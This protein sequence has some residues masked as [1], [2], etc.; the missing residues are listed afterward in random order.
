MQLLAAAAMLAAPT[1]VGL[2]G[3][4]AAAAVW[5]RPLWVGAALLVL[6]VPFGMVLP[7]AVALD[8]EGIGRRFSRRGGIYYALQAGGGVAGAITLGLVLP[9]HIGFA[10]TL[11]ALAGG[12]GLLAIGLLALRLTARRSEAASGAPADGGRPPGRRTAMWLAL[13]L[14]MLGL[15]GELMW[16]RALVFYFSGTLYAYAMVSAVFVA[17]LMVGGLIGAWLAAVRRRP[18]EFLG[19][20]VLL[21][22]VA[23]ALSAYWMGDPDDMPRQ[24]MLIST[25]VQTFASRLA[26]MALISALVAGPGALLMGMCFPLLLRLAGGEPGVSADKP[27]ESGSVGR[28]ARIV[29]R[30]AAW[31]AVGSAI[32]PVLAMGML[33]AFW[34]QRR[35]LLAVAVGYLLAALWAEAVDPATGWH[36]SRPRA[37]RRSGADDQDDRDRRLAHARRSRIPWLNMVLFGVGGVVCMWQ[38]Q[39]KD[40]L[41]RAA[42]YWG[43][44][45]GQ[46]RALSPDQMTETVT[47]LSLRESPDGVVAVRRDTATGLTTLLIDR[48]E[49]GDD[50]PDGLRV[51]RREGLLPLVLSPRVPRRALVVG[52]GTGA[53]AAPLVQSGVARTT[54]AE[55]VGPVVDAAMDQ[56]SHANDALNTHRMAE[57]TPLDDEPAPPA[58]TQPASSQP[59]DALP[60]GPPQLVV[61]HA[62]GRTVLR[63]CPPNLDLI[64]VDI[65]FPTTAGAG[66]LFSREFYS[67][68]Y[69]RLAPGG[70][71][72]HWLPLWQIA[73]EQVASVIAAFRAGF[74]VD[75]SLSQIDLPATRLAV[76]TVPQPGRLMLGLVGCRGRID[77]G[78]SRLAAN[79]ARTASACDATETGVKLA[80]V[81]LA[82]PDE[83]WPDLLDDAILADWA[84]DAAPATDLDPRTELLGPLGESDRYGDRN[85]DRLVALGYASADYAARLPERLGIP[86]SDVN[87]EAMRAR[88]M[89]RSQIIELLRALPLAQRAG[90]LREL[91]GKMDLANRRSPDDRMWQFPIRRIRY[92][93]ALTLD[94]DPVWE[95]A[96]AL[97]AAGPGQAA[98]YRRCLEDLLSI[99]DETQKEFPYDIE[100]LWEQAKVQVI[101][102]EGASESEAAERFKAAE[103]ALKGAIDLAPRSAD[104]HYRKA[105]LLHDRGRPDESADALQQAINLRDPR[106]IP[107]AFRKL[108]ALL[109]QER[110][111]APTT[112]ADR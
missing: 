47:L 78:R 85:I 55:V 59:D 45:S 26:D 60:P 112:Q 17:A 3:T 69:D 44:F 86:A 82:D 95:Q 21:I 93:M 57:F 48:N 28:S 33:L 29:G 2:A 62:D 88:C 38:A 104:L 103:E 79:M 96:R 1:L 99:L 102:A 46:Q 72:V 49:Q 30:V 54:V 50:S 6:N 58:S 68:A 67:L 25:P 5:S 4:R 15:A 101:L 10:R 83:L 34:D 56:F 71:L 97:A 23:V 77:L 12:H 35:G 61:R 80:D 7:V 66:G 73:P 107:G 91:R 64:L 108:S 111:P 27:G 14:G 87:A 11:W 42:Y 18:G 13:W 70:L 43:V 94:V 24:W 105:Q 19:T 90:E 37:G 40:S 74:G 81:G 109:E 22:A 52:L 41:F 16:T 20:I 89:A 65:V 106:E 63:A 53:T 8:G 36:R 31:S 32:G 75:Q 39:Q 51:Q 92:N 76:V 100:A 84:A 98:E 9:A 110:R